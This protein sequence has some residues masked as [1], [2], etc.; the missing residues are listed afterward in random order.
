LSLYPNLKRLPSI[1]SHPDETLTFI[2]VLFSPG[3][4]M[5]GDLMQYGACP[6]TIIDVILAID[7]QGKLS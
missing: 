1:N 4:T 5:G 2:K 7:S 3:R 6:A